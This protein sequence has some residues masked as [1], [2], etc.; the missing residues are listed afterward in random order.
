M[1]RALRASRP[2]DSDDHVRSGFG[3]ESLRRALRATRPLH[4]DDSD[5]HVRSDFGGESL[6]RALRASRPL[7]SDDSDDHVR[8]GFGGESLRRALRAKVPDE[9][10]LHFFGGPFGTLNL[11]LGTPYLGGGGI[12][13]L[14]R[15]DPRGIPGGALE[16]CF[17]MMHQVKV[18]MSRA[19]KPTP[20]GS[21]AEQPPAA[22]AT[23]VD[24]SAE[25]SKSRTGS[26]RSGVS[27][28]QVTVKHRL[29]LSREGCTSVGRRRA[30]GASKA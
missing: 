2:L 21:A 8:S 9:K 6:R 26:Q 4:L 22:G 3:G 20:W 7:D 14:G 1:R 24:T 29:V 17:Y 15:C 5:D 25:R 16:V 27:K 19:P 23:A 28:A 30:P 10:N 18:G 11:G 13:T 12:L